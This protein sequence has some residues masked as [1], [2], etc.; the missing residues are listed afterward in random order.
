MV[1]GAT[2]KSPE[3]YSEKIIYFLAKKFGEL[4]NFSYLCNVNDEG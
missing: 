2:G 1:I 4:R 3:F